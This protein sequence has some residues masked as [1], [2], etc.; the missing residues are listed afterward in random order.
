MFTLTGFGDEISPNLTEQLDLLESEGVKHLELRG[1]WDKNVLDLTDEEIGRVKAE[2]D[3]RGFGVSAIASPI[4]KYPITE[5]LAPHLE[6][7]GRA[8]DLAEFF[9]A[10]YIRVFSFYVPPRQAAEYRDQVMEYMFGLAE[11]AKGRNVTLALENEH[12]L[13]GDLPERSL[14]LV[15]TLNSS[16]WTTCYDPCN[17]I[18]E[19]LHPFTQAFPLLADT[20]HYVHVKDG[21]IATHKICVAGEG[22]GGIPETLAALKRSGYDGFLSLEPHLLIAGANSGVSG[23]ELFRGAIRA[24]TGIIATL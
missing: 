12:G 13:Y 8:L 17:Y 21:S 9:A 18:M 5:P 2:L 10:P 15:E 22:D 11:A 20:I 14:D 24:L 1:V 19:G 23:P 16:Q 7:F 6:R 4:G 3:S